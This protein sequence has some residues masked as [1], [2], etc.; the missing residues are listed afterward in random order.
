MQSP[1]WWLVMNLPEHTLMAIELYGPKVKHHPGSSASPMPP[2]DR[3]PDAHTPLP[4]FHPACPH[5][6]ATRQ[7]RVVAH[8]RLVSAVTARHPSHRLLSQPHTP[9]VLRLGLQCRD[10][11]VDWSHR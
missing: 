3:S 11:G 2:C 5:R 7:V 9:G 6:P 4:H 8:V 1:M 10:D